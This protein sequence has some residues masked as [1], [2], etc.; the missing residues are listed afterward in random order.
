MKAGFKMLL[1]KYENMPAPAK[2]SLWFTICNIIQKG[3]ALISTPIFTRI[4]TTQQ[5]GVYTVYQS[6][7]QILAIFATL[8]LSAGVFNNGLTKY[9]E[10]K[11][12]LVASLQGL[13]TT[14]TALLF[15][16]YIFQP[17][18]WNEKLGLSTLFVLVMF[19]QL[20]LEPAY[21]F[22]A[23][24]Q[25][26]R[27]QYKALIVTTMIIALGSPFL[28]IISV[29]AT[30]YKAEAR[31]LSFV[32]VQVILGL[33]SYIRSFIV[34]KK[35]YDNFFWK[36]ALKFNIPLMPHYLSMTLLNQ[37]DRIMIDK[38]CGASEAAI[39]GIAYTLAMMMTIITGAIN[40]SFIPYTYQNI[41]AKR[42]SDISKNANFLLLLVAMGCIGAMAFGPELISIFATEEYYAAIWIMPPVA[43]SVFFMFLYPLF[44]N[45]EFYF[46][47]T[48]II[49][50]ASCSGALLNIALNYICIRLYGYIAAGYTT[51]FCYI[52]FSFAHYFA[53]RRIVSREKDMEP[54][55]NMRFV[56]ALSVGM[57]IIMVLMLVSYINKIIRYTVITVIVIVVIK[58]RRYVFSKLA[59]IR[60][61]SER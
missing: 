60:N 6:W 61:R 27:Y 41:K 40:S 56:L 31:V 13:S 44:A 15:V 23:A 57:L 16:I 20:L 51:L 34:G 25:R 26:Y 47:K 29:M 37:S 55:Y 49:M 9:P 53:Y 10:K 5:Y 50:V 7:Y 19:A 4:L 1:D 59:E 22:W 21:L 38:M 52:V 54:T 17:D 24:E 36:Y 35:F 32:F 14:V 28:G 33:I 30:N 12:E 43:A 3:I 8:N 48:K 11:N 39:Y 46:E 18:F 58:K 42:Y 45:V 2:A